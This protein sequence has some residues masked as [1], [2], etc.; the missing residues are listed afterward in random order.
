MEM[1]IRDQP[2]G[3][4]WL[5]VVAL[6]L[7]MVAL[8]G[9]FDYLTGYEVSVAVL[10]YFPIAYAAWRLGWL[11]SF[12]FAFLCV[13]T[14]TGVDIAAGHHYTKGWMLW[15]Q[16]IMRLLCFC[17][18]AYSFDFFKRRS[19]RQNE[20][21]RRLEAGT[22]CICSSC[23]KVRDANDN[24]VELESFLRDNTAVQAQAKLCPDCARAFYV[25]S[26]G[27]AV[28]RRPGN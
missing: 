12:V 17:F 13:A 3:V 9:W 7:G 25:R 28:S 2:Q 19:D 15:N 18:V 22:M 4:R 16:V 6:T 26:P 27:S 11:W 21:I 10:Y 24:W 23:R 5:G 20:K 8:V 1:D 14:L